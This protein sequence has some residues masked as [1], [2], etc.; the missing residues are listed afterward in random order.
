MLMSLKSFR[1]RT[2]P[3][4]MAGIFLGSLI[5]SSDSAFKP[6]IFLFALLTTLSLQ[7]LANLANELGDARKGTDR[8]ERLG[9]QYSLQCG[10]SS[11]EELKK[12]VEIFT[13]LSLAFG[14]ALVWIAFDADLSALGSFSFYVMLL[15]GALA[16]V[17][18]LGYTLG[19]KPYGYMALGDLGVFLFFGLLS[20]LGSYFL[21]AKDLYWSLVF[22]ASGCG[23]LSVAVLN[24]NNMRDIESDR[25]TRVTIPIKIGLRNAKIYHTALIACSQVLFLLFVLW[26]SFHWTSLLFLIF[27]PLWYWQITETWK[28]EGKELDKLLPSL[29][30][31]TLA[32]CILLGLFC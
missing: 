20:V 13:G 5:A 2:L 25:R 11:L 1:L 22:A 4:S 30:L 14:F 12:L 27:I 9:P 26:R 15:L 18:A 6:G 21:M 28:R 8:A 16:V 10:T 32:Q 19:R 17:A 23:L 29:S 3:L 31:G 7:I 24:L